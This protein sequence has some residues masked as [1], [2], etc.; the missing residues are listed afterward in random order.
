MTTTYDRGPAPLVLGAYLRA[1][2][3][4]KGLKLCDAAEFIRSS[5]AKLSGMETGQVAQ[6]W[7]DV[8]ALA[9]FYGVTDWSTIV[10]ALRLAGQQP[11]DPKRRTGTIHDNT[12]GWTDRMP[13]CEQHASAICVY[14]SA[15]IP[16]IVQT[17]EYPVAQLPLLP[18]S[19]QPQDATVILDGATLLR[20]FGNPQAM[21]AQM[22]H[23]QRLGTSPF[24][25]RI[26]VVPFQA[27]VIPP[28][29]NLHRFQLHGHE[30]LAEETWSALYTTG[31]DSQ[32]ARD[33]LAAGLAA[34]EDPEA[35]AV[36]LDIAR[37]RFEQL[38]KDPESDPLLEELTA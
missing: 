24:G 13:A 31:P 12:E 16:R 8:C 9:R 26:L 19:T 35:S 27:G 21:A 30:V 7:Q 11:R 3:Q 4:A 2:R 28:P 23:L 10:G 34:A 20:T 32:P 38:A 5:A 29:G 17:T 33:R 15:T 18:S 25:P 1:L 14:A 37:R 36:L 6:P 22:A